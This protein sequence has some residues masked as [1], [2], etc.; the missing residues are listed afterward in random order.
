M[1]EPIVTYG[2]GIPTH[3]SRG[4]VGGS[5]AIGPLGSVSYRWN[6]TGGAVAKFHSV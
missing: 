1:A 3:P 4:W 6:E 2:E 5:L